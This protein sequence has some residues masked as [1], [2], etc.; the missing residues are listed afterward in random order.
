MNPTK[1][2][3]QLV[4]KSWPWTYYINTQPNFS[5]L[6]GFSRISLWLVSRCH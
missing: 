3:W 5:I 2:T 1:V 6:A 4:L